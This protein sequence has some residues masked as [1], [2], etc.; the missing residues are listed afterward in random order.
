MIFSSWFPKIV[1][2]PSSNRDYFIWLLKL[3][4]TVLKMYIPNDQPK[5]ITYRDYK[6]FYNKHFL[7]ASQSELN[8]LGMPLKNKILFG[9]IM[10]TLWMPNYWIMLLWFARNCDTN[11]KNFRSNTDRNCRSDTNKIFGTQWSRFP[12]VNLRLWMG[13]Y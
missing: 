11:T 13:W 4:V 12:Q 6:K 3:E 1:A 7:E 5:L 10:L 9:L 8:K 2:E